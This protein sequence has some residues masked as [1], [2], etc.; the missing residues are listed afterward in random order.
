MET[1]HR[2]DNFIL[3]K[4][5]LIKFALLMFETDFCLYVFLFRFPM[6]DVRKEML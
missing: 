3:F 6:N 4:N 5:S 1:L 2:V